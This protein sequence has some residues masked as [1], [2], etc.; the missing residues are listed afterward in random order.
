MIHSTHNVLLYTAHYSA[1]AV[2]ASHTR[3]EPL[4]RI[5][6]RLFVASMQA[7]LQN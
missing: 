6:A 4:V 7:D 2:F 1:T 5:D 3:V